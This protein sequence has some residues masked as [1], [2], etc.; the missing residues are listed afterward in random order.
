MSGAGLMPLFGRLQGV[1]ERIEAEGMSTLHM[2]ESDIMS[3]ADQLKAHLTR[4][5]EPVFAVLR[6]V[7]PILLIDQM[8]GRLQSWSRRNVPADS[9][10]HR[11]T[12]GS[13]GGRLQSWPR[14]DVPAYSSRHCATGRSMGGHWID[15]SRGFQ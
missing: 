9:S 13:M 7:K 8:G 6:R 11:A 3:F 1:F 10:R 14:R 15:S 12:G 5:P 4:Y 2:A